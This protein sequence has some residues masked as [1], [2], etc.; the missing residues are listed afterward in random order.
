MPANQPLR[1]ALA[2]RAG[3]EWPARSG[4]AALFP[5]QPGQCRIGTGAGA[6]FEA[7]RAL[8]PALVKLGEELSDGLLPG[9]SLFP[10]PHAA[11]LDVL[12]DSAIPL[13]PV[14]RIPTH[15]PTE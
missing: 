8:V 2:A 6:G 10:P 12:D 9:P 1:G 13:E 3:G 15:H 14:D 7:D 11:N 4:L 5:R